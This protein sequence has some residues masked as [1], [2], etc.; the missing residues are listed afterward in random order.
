[1]SN[2][3]EALWHKDAIIYQLHVRGFFDSDNDGIGDFP[4]LT[5]RLDYLKELGVNTLWLQPFYPSPLRDD[6]YDLADFTG[7][8]P[9]Y[10]TLDDFREFLDEAHKRDLRVITELIINHTSNEHPWFQRARKAPPG[11]PERDFYVWSETNQKYEG[12]RIIFTDTEK[13]N[14]AWDDEA[15][16]YY[17][18]RFFSHQPDLNFD[19]PAVI[20]AVLDAMRFWFDMGV[21]GMRLDAIPYLCERDGTNNENLPETHAVIKHL[22]A[23]LDRHYKNRIFLAEAN[24]WPEDVR[25]YFGDGDECHMAFHFPLMPRVFMAVAQEDRHPITEILGQTPSIPENCQWAVFLRNHDELTLEMVTDKERDYMYN[26]YASDKRARVNVGIRRRLAP[27]MEGDRERIE[28]LNTI[29]LSMPGS[30]IIYFGDEIGMGDNIY[31]GDRN[32]VRTPMQWSPDRN[33]GFSRADPQR[34]YLP[35]VMDPLYGFQTVNVESQRRNTSSLLNWMRNLIATRKIY[36]A[37]GRGTIEF[38]HPG[39]RKVLAFLREYDGETLLCIFN[40][41][42][43]AQ[44]VEL[45]LAKYK[46]YVPEELVGKVSFPAI[47]ELPYFISL[48]R[49]AFY[50]FRLSTE[51]APPLW[52]VDKLPREELPVLVL[53]DGLLSMLSTRPEGEVQD[54]LAH[55]TRQQ[56]EKEIIPAFLNSQRWYKGTGRQ[57]TRMT[58]DMHHEWKSPEGPRWLPMMVRVELDNTEQQS[59]FLPIGM[60]LGDAADNQYHTLSPWM[61]SRVRQ[62]ARVGMLYDALGE[63]AFC[64][65][66]LNSMRSSART[67]FSA[68]E[69]VCT[70]TEALDGPPEPL[71][72]QRPGLALTNLAIIYGEKYF[73]KVYR[74]VQ[75]GIN[76]EVEMGHFLSEVSPCAYVPPLAGSISYQVGDSV[77]TIAVL[78]VYITNQ[79]SGWSN[80]QNYLE[81]HFRLLMKNPELSQ[82]TD[83]HDAFYAQMA[84][85]GFSTAALHRALSVTT[86]NPDF[87]PERITDDEIAALQEKIKDSFET[88]FA[89]LEHVLPDLTERSKKTASCLLGARDRILDM[90]N[91][92]LPTD[93]PLYKSRIHGNYHLG[94]TL[95][96]QNDYFIVDFEGE[97]RSATQSAPRQAF[98]LERRCL[99]DV[100]LR[101]GSIAVTAT[102]SGLMASSGE[103]LEAQAAAWQHAAEKAF[104]KAYLEASADCPTHPQDEKQVRRLLNL[105]LLERALEELDTSLNWRPDWL[106]FTTLS[107]VCLIDAK[108]ELIKSMS[109][110]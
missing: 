29:L 20:D 19:N 43:T 95:V 14:W 1:M 65:L 105:Y 91:T 12:T 32:A 71:E 109:E 53:P 38:L 40:L 26:T 57:I 60:L 47:G 76:P 85:L 35:P 106:D 5:S 49:Y 68:G 31:L 80:A 52:H 62:R 73:L 104:L 86:G 63:D 8:H 70:H 23:E 72:I 82:E 9:D 54:L 108:E 11:S 110:K 88:A 55:K 81:R 94:Q 16:A 59:Y 100:F 46:G 93:P 97:P 13:S 48:P 58:L 41:S 67:P 42:H 18:H 10:G 90:I 102:S 98:A 61:L 74:R 78:H 89:K 92:P 103:L 79:G 51:V 6:G 21:D 7:I 107:L 77:T 84:S 25:H 3:D 39:N 75:T 50:W 24:Q 99:D 37:F 2:S 101:H 33:G 36:K 15:K 56:L 4:G 96:V 27:L 45:D 69:I 44:P 28:L 17:W 83:T 30:P 87:D 64:M 34:L 66:M 22:R